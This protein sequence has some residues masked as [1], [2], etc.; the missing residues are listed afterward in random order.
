MGFVHKFTKNGIKFVVDGNTGN[1]HILDD[2]AYDILD[3]YGRLDKEDIV[4]LFKNKYRE[5]DIEETLVELNSLKAQNLIFADEVSF[6]N[7]ENV[8]KALCLHVS[9]DCNLRCKY[10]F[11]GEGSFCGERTLMDFIVGK[12]AIDFLIKNSGNRKNIEVDFFGGEPLLNFEMIK[13]LV[14]YAKEEAIKNGKNIKFTLTTNAVLL[15]GE[16][17]EFVNE[18]MD[19]VVL[20]LDGRKWINDSMRILPDGSGS[21]DLIVDNIKNFIKMRGNKDYY[22]RGTFTSKNLDFADDVLYLL[23]LGIK[24]ISLEPVVIEEDVDYALRKEHLPVIYKEYERLMNLYLERK[25]AGS[26]FLFFHFLIDINKGPCFK[27]RIKG[28]GAGVEYFA[29]TPSGDIYPC[30]QFVGIEKFKMGSL[31]TGLDNLSREVFRN[32]DIYHKEEC[33][34][35]WAKMY[36]GGGC[37][38]NAYKFNGDVSKPYELACNMH[39]KRVECAITIKAKE[40]EGLYVDEL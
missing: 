6:Q 21:Y 22:V 4:S 26:E 25:K 32:N 17:A 10:C 39:R 1:I 36:C 12:K 2:I 15:E 8:V 7:D 11:A 31:D 38:A 18:Y 5:E 35:C 27:K 9:H 16:I 33:K 24:N 20:S 34:K 30:H 14:Y 13:D 40:L 19:N 37:I 29:V 23:D 28:C 3:Y